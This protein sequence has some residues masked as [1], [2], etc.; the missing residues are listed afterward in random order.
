MRS[1]DIQVRI[2]VFIQD[3]V[4]AHVDG[5]EIIRRIRQRL[6]FAR[7]EAEISVLRDANEA[8]GLVGWFNQSKYSQQLNGY[9]S[10]ATATMKPASGERRKKTGQ[11]LID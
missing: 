11:W 5:V 7:Q 2:S 10:W 4:Y 1:D 3:W 9:Q 6:I 8:K